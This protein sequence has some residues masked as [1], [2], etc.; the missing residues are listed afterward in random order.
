MSRPGTLSTAPAA[1]K[2]FYNAIFKAV[3][4]DNSESAAGL[5][6]PLGSFKATGQFVEFAIDVDADCL[7]R[8]R[9]RVFGRAGLVAH[10]AANNCC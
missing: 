8:P 9:C 6:H 4:R 2:L 7:K 3:K 5:Q 10:G 1:Q